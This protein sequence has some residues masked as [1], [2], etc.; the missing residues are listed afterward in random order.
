MQHDNRSQPIW[1]RG[2]RLIGLEQRSLNLCDWRFSFDEKSGAAKRWS[3][4]RSSFTQRYATVEWFAKEAPKEAR[5]RKWLIYVQQEF[6]FVNARVNCSINCSNALSGRWADGTMY[7]A[8]N[9]LTNKRVEMC[10]TSSEMA[11]TCNRVMFTW[12][13]T[14]MSCK[15]MQRL[16]KRKPHGSSVILVHMVNFARSDM[17][18]RSMLCSST[19]SAQRWCKQCLLNKMNS[20]A[21]F[22]HPKLKSKYDE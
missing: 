22:S 2:V 18:K 3:K 20:F 16:L 1:E 6:S 9:C 13:G 4:L 8:P 14:C 10:L 19:N 11:A 5:P 15:L 7:R 12:S 17:E 21:W